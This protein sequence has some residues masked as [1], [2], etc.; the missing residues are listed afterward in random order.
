MAS[1]PAGAAGGLRGVSAWFGELCG[2]SGAGRA[3]CAC[4]G[5]FMWASG[6]LRGPGHKRAFLW[7]SAGAPGCGLAWGTRRRCG[8][9]AGVL[10][11]PVFSFSLLLALLLSSSLSPFR[12][13]GRPPGAGGGAHA[14]WRRVSSRWAAL[15]GPVG[16]CGI[17]R[18]LACVLPLGVRVGIPGRAPPARPVS[19]ILRGLLSLSD[20]PRTGRSPLVTRPGTTGPRGLGHAP[21]RWTGSSNFLLLLLL[22]TSAAPA[23][24][25]S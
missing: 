4:S 19:G 8:C 13:F 14:R 9:P 11:R 17:V 12:F 6:A 7:V 3:G 20:A 22:H 21:I 24:R 15:G 18:V 16:I 23:R 5:V 25:P 2:V 1:Q 10:R